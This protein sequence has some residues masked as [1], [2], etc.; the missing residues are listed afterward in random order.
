[1]LTAALFDSLV[2]FFHKGVII[3]LMRLGKKGNRFIRSPNTP[4]YNKI[5]LLEYC[6]RFSMRFYKVF[7]YCISVYFHKYRINQILINL[8]RKLKI[9][10]TDEILQSNPAK[11]AVSICEIKHHFKIVTFA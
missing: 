7:D 2:K 11:M 5:V 1:M 4:G 3:N 6:K 8:S 9:T 10:F